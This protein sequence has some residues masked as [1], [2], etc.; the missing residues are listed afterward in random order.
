MKHEPKIAILL[1]S[2][3]GGAYIRR[4]LD[5]I[6]SQSYSN[7]VL[8]ISDDGSTDETLDIVYEYKKRLGDGRVQ[9]FSG[10]GQGFAWNFISLVDKVPGDFDY[11]AFSDQDDEWLNF[12]LDKA[13]QLLITDDSIPQLYCGRTQLVDEDNCRLGLSPLFTRKPCFRNALVQSI[14]GGNTMIFNRASKNI[15]LKTPSNSKIISH[16]WWIYILVTGCGGRVIYDK[17]PTILYRQHQ[18]NIIGANKG[19]SARLSRLLGVIDGRYK[20][21]IQANLD[22]LEEIEINFTEDNRFVLNNSIRA[23]K[24]GFFK[25]I[26]IFSKIKLFRQTLVGSFAFIIAIMMNKV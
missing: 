10:P 21:W 16:D 26:Y 9:V 4:Q 7:W 15:I 6:I 8:Y 11:Y 25:R 20:K 23:R 24:S 5:S 18:N 1:C 19:I 3:N 14:A 13:V 12:K 22:V 2:Y 17:Q